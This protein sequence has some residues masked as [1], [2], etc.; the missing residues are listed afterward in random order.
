MVFDFDMEKVATYV[1]DKKK[2]RPTKG[3]TVGLKQKAMLESQLKMTLPNVW[4]GEKEIV[5]SSIVSYPLEST[6][7]VIPC[8]VAW[9]SGDHKYVLLIS[10][11]DHKELVRLLREQCQALLDV[12]DKNDGRLPKKCGTKK[13]VSIKYIYIYIYFFFFDLKL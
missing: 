2:P 9:E 8:I 12:L 10:V 6:K 5:D 3:V 1:V 13:D 11:D 7:E 4:A